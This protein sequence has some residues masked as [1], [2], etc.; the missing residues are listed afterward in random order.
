MGVYH[1]TYVPKLSEVCL[2]FNSACNFSCRGCIGDTYPLDCHLD[3]KEAA[4]AKN[5][6]LNINKVVPYLKPLSLKKAIFLGKEPTID[7][8][9]LPLARIL[10]KDFFTHNIFITNGWEYVEDEAIDEACVSIKAITL[11]LFEDF[12]GKDDPLRVLNNFKKYAHNHN[13]KLRAESIFIPGYID[14]IEIEKIAKFISS[15]DST[16]PYR[17][18]GYIPYSENDRFRRPTKSEM[19]EVKL[20]AEKYLQNVSILHFGTKVKHEVKR[21]Y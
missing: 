7:R 2:Y 9:F 10:K 20:V 3:K 16:I 5:R 17:I 6:A 14:N 11:E 4:Q 21:L 13:I 19:E 1:I 15:V 18:D 12:T 8:D